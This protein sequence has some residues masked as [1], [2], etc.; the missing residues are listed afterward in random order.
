MEPATVLGAV[1][2]WRTQMVD[3]QAARSGDPLQPPDP[4]GQRPDPDPQLAAVDLDIP[5]GRS[6]RQGRER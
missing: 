5:A 3:A 2:S 6:G 1:A 4:P